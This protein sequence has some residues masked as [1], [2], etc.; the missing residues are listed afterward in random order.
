M[1]PRKNEAQN[2]GPQHGSPC[3]ACFRTLQSTTMPMRNRPRPDGTGRI[4][5]RPDRC[6]RKQDFTLDALNIVRSFEFWRR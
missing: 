6:H 4:Q 5:T 3:D 1:Y 2:H